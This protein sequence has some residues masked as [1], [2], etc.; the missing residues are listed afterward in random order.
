MAV[1]DTSDLE[2]EETT[3]VELDDKNGNELFDADGNRRSVTIYGPGSRPFAV[4]KSKANA[5]T[6]KRI[7]TNGGRQAAN[8][9][10]DIDATASFLAAITKSFNN[11]GLKDE[12]Q[13]E[14]TYR[15]LYANI[16]VGYIT[17]KVNGAAGD[18]ANF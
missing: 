10:E 18:W 3:V 15:E 16:K 11:F 2:V 14:K 7:R 8:P 12:D 17:D 9:D 6:L 1:I 4:A 5:R 13:V